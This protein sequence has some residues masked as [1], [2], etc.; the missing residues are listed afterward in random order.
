[1][2]RPPSQAS[3]CAGG[4]HPW[5]DTSLPPDERARLVVAQMTQAE[6]LGYLA[7]DGFN[8][9]GHTG[10]NLGIPRLGVP[11]V[12]QTDA[13]G[14]VRQGQATALPA[15]VSLAATFDRGLAK[16]YGALVGDEAKNKG[17]DILLGP[18]VNIHRVP[19]N[20]RN[21]EYY[22]EDPEL[23]K[24]MAVEY[25]EGLQRTGVMGNVKHFAGNNQEGV[26]GGAG[27]RYKVNAVIDE[28]T[29][30]EIYLPAFEAAVKDADVA[31][32]M[33]AYNKVNGEYR[34]R[35]ARSCGI[36]SRASGASTA[37][38]SPTTSR[39]CTRPSTR[40]TAAWTSRTPAPC[41]SRPTGSPPPWPQG[42]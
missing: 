27:S 20:G 9:G 1:M 41:G 35:T 34:A 25:I 29:L 11:D 16:R 14:G 22:G 36:C 21:F 40:P 42:S 13:S 2:R 5:C 24:V 3:P 15:S 32:V 18:G 7:T 10:R 6:K 23:A 30:R 39:A 8:L 33:T 26:P 4:T 17:N 12:D 38:R 19:N 31:T 37:S 28:R